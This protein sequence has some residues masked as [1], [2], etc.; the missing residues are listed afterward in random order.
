LSDSMK[1]MGIRGERANKRS[2]I[3][4]RRRAVS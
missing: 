4:T 1:D 2:R 3:L